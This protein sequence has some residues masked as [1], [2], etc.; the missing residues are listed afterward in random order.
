[1]PGGDAIGRDR[2]VLLMSL[3][4]DTKNS[5]DTG[6]VKW[7]KKICQVDGRGDE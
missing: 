5:S 2:K 1:M 7:I 4:L 6:S 3:M